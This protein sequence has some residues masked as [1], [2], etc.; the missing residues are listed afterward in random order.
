MSATPMS[1]PTLLS[2]YSMARRSSV[3]AWSARSNGDDRR[4]LG[5]GGLGRFQRHRG[6]QPLV[7]V[8]GADLHQVVAEPGQFDGV[9]ADPE[10]GQRRDLGDDLRRRGPRLA[11]EEDRRVDDPPF[12]DQRDDVARCLTDHLG[13]RLHRLRRRLLATRHWRGPELGDAVAEPVGRGRQLGV[14]Q[15]GQCVAQ[16]EHRQHADRQ[17]HHRHHG[18]HPDDEL[19][20]QRPGT[21]AAH[22]GDRNR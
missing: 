14:D 15:P 6:H 21:P 10:G 3:G 18:R 2:M 12:L 22:S 13:E 7:A 8:A 20:A 19:T 5:H 4:L 9:P 11:V 16:R 17:Q 1:F